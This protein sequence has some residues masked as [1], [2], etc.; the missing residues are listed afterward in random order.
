[1]NEIEMSLDSD[2]D[3]DVLNL[4]DGQGHGM[5][6][7]TQPII[8]VDQVTLANQWRKRSKRQKFCIVIGG[9]LLLVGLFALA[10]FLIVRLIT[11]T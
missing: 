10:V 5:G 6:K 4:E 9:F 8:T 3:V 7:D 1:M 11:A 2:S